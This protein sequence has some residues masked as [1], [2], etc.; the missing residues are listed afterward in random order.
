[1]LSN[2]MKKKL[3]IVDDDPFVLITMRQLFEH[4]G[5]EVFTVSSGQE[6]INELDRGFQGVIL[7]DV[8]MPHMD[9]WT[10]IRQII[11][12]GYDKKNVISMLTAREEYDADAEDLRKYIRDYLVKPFDLQPLVNTVN[13]YFSVQ[14]QKK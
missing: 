10:T 7:M 1:V 8:M 6:C 3:M 9:G 14:K 2:N 5:F 12:K 11:A 4:E 13:G